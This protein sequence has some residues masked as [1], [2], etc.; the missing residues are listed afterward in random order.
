MGDGLHTPETI[1]RRG[2]L[3]KT[4]KWLGI[5]A[6]G[7]AAAEVVNK[8]VLQPLANKQ[9]GYAPF[10]MSETPVPLE[11]LSLAETIEAV[12]NQKDGDFSKLDAGEDAYRNAHPELNLSGL[13]VDPDGKL[14]PVDR[15]EVGIFR[16]VPDEKGE[17]RIRW[18]PTDIGDNNLA[19]I[20][21]RKDIDK[22]FP[23]SIIIARRVVGSEI[24]AGTKY[25]HL[26]PTEL[27]G[28]NRTPESGGEWLVLVEIKREPGGKN[29]FLSAYDLAQRPDGKSPIPKEPS[30]PA[31]AGI[32]A[33][34]ITIEAAQQI[35]ADT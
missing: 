13:N 34:S 17:M 14:I 22:E 16:V 25:A 15:G 35:I 31:I 7:I 30:M 24:D 21:T 6:S 3:T 19:R 1:T 9:V 11:S 5:G 28:S 20:V 18:G 32:F 27:K 33:D 26:G 10:T 29:V 2:F 8:K 23:G 12:R 4:A